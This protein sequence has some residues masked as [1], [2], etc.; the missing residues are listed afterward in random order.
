[1]RPNIFPPP[2]FSLDEVKGIL[3]REFDLS[4]EIEPLPGDIGQNFHVTASDGREFLFKIANPGEDRFSLEA[5]N[6]VL[7]YLNQKDFAFQLPQI[8]PN[9]KGAEIIE[10]RDH[11]GH[12]HLARLFTWLKGEFL[13]DVNLEDKPDLLEDLGRVLGQLDRA[14]AELTLPQARRY[15]HWDLQNLLDWQELT[16]YISPFPRKRLV[17]YFLLQFETEVVPELAHLRR[18]LI[19]NDANDYNILVSKTPE[20]RWQITGLIDFGDMVESYLLFEPAVALAYTISSAE[21][22]LEAALPL[23]K[24][25][26]SVFPLSEKEIRLLYYCLAGRLC[27]SL[28]MSAYQKH[29]RPE[30]EYVTISEKPVWRLLQKWQTIN[31]L[32]AEDRFRASLGLGPA[33]RGLSPELIINLRQQHLSRS[34]SLHYRKPLKIVRGALQYLYDEEGQT[35]LDCINN[36][37]HV[38]H[39]HPRVVR[40][41]QR[42]SALLNTNTR[43]LHDYLVTYAQRLLATLPEPLQVVFLVNS[44]SEANELA[45]RLA[46]TYT[47]RRDMIVIDHAYHGNTSALIDLSPYKFKGRGGQGPGPWTHTVTMPDIYRGPYRS[48]DP[49]AAQ[50]YAQE[51]VEL[52]ARLEAE[53]K[54]PAGFMAEAI[55][56]CGG[57]VPLPPGYLQTVYPAVRK[58]GGVCIADEV[59]IGFGRLGTHFWGFEQQQVVPDIVTMGKPIGNG[60][61]LAA[62]ATTSEIAAA[63]ANGME[64]FNTF[65]G[66]PVSCAIGLAVLEVI[67]EEQ[68]QANAR[69]LGERLQ[70]GLRELQS[71]YPVIG[72]VRGSGLFLGVELIKDPATLEPAPELAEAVVESL[73]A[74]GILFSTEGPFNNVLKFKPPLVITQNDADRILETLDRIL[75]DKG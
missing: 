59:Q 4:G 20:G 22:P 66:N 58:A 6:K 57:Q 3:Q 31:P 34:L 72:D 8:I 35:Y 71:K 56:G 24:G 69:R 55:L 28:M 32:Q 60:H 21:N 23:L 27:L 52:I 65:G 9:Q 43:F 7:A 61:P 54:A 18:S 25:Y 44:G 74:E 26:N 38:G 5:Q 12:H 63:F 46:Y 15:W 41:G 50:K 47:G 19:Y 14:L 51:V 45:L 36:V 67:E 75:K 48:S 39:C 68:L 16:A 13:A 40:A 1:M 70:Q 29:L 53:G 42:Q 2:T 62:V 49:E 64:Y 10:V 37:A 73:K 33:S 17:E 11:R 30:D